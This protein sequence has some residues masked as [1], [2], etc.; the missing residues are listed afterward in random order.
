MNEIKTA[1][2]AG[3]AEVFFDW[4]PPLVFAAV[5]TVLMFMYIA[6]PFTVASASMADTIQV[7]DSVIVS[8]L[9]YTPGRGD[10]ILFQK[11]GWQG[12]YDEETGQ[13]IPLCKRIIGIEGDM[14]G[15]DGGTLFLNN[16]PLDEPYIREIMRQWTAYWPMALPF[17]V[18]EG[19]V[20][21]M[22]DNR[23][24]SH[25]SRS[26]DIGFV[27]QRSIIGPVIWR[28]AP[29]SRFGPVR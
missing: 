17:T 19:F 5:C 25:D 14:I 7:N 10:I 3:F 2:R 9:P 21:V 8:R 28:I 26:L 23:N 12:T 1:K 27:D 13:Y 29:L 11:Y 4:A 24:N 20:F 22:G 15:Y 6:A 18:P 16:E